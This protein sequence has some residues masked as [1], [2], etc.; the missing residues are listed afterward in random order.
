MRG[1]LLVAALA[2]AHMRI[3][4]AHA[5]QT[6]RVRY[7]RQAASDHPRA[8][9]ANPCLVNVVS[10][11]AGSSPRMRGK[12]A[13]RICRTANQR[14]IPAHAGQTMAEPGFLAT[15]TDHPRACG[16]NPTPIRPIIAGVGSSPRMRGKP[17]R[18]GRH[19][20]RGRI[21]PAHAGQTSST[22]TESSWITDHPRACG[23]NP[24]IFTDKEYMIGSSPRMRGKLRPVTARPSRIRIIPAHAGQTVSAVAQ[25]NTLPDHPRAC[26]ANDHKRATHVCSS[27]SSP[28]MR[29]KRAG[30]KH[31]GRRV[32]IIPAHA[33][34]TKS[35]RVRAFSMPDHPRACGANRPLDFNLKSERGS[36][37]RMRGKLFCVFVL[38][39]SLRIIPA[40]AG[41][42]P[43]FD[44]L[45]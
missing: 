34:Q 43:P 25:H 39:F 12:L 16:A 5:G 32:R 4:P 2:D 24:Q 35:K 21:I 3:I 38:C 14:I 22:Y 23:A 10:D 40:H 1:K 29:G 41:Q 42:T 20:L 15:I 30:G 17:R 45:S 11:C 19:A 13:T 44:A 33:G 36:S 37:P 18:R 8:C 27:G 31:D 26:G 6:T 28:R 9:G 7:G